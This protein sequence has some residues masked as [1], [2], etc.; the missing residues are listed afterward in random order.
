MEL[1]I[2]SIILIVV[3]TFESASVQLALYLWS[4][5]VIGAEIGT[6]TGGG[7][8]LEITLSSRSGILIVWI[9]DETSRQKLTVFS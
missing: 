2:C 9:E 3:L 7:I 8:V 5:T 4:G 6:G 1:Y